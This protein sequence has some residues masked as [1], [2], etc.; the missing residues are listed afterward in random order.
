M[1]IK[2]LH[3][4]LHSLQNLLDRGVEMSD[5]QKKDV[6]RLRKQVRGLRAD[7]QQLKAENRRLMSRINRLLGIR[8]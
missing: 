8:R 1:K 4:K 2:N 3:G 7:K 5:N 6:A